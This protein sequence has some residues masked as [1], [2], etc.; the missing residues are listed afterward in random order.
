MY[1]DNV[2]GEASDTNI[3]SESSNVVSPPYSSVVKI[4]KKD[5]VTPTNIGVIMLCQIPNVSHTIA[6]IVLQ[7]HG[8]IQKLIEALK[9]G[10]EWL[11]KLTT[12][13]TTGKTRKLNKS[14]RD[15]IVQYLIVDS[16]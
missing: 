10:R 4:K 7:E 2:S 9:Q 8:T 16:K 11:D 14:A 3:G 12:T 5:N 13:T 1:Y 15:N 6:T